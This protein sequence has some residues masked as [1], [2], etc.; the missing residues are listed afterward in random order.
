MDGRGDRRRQAG[1]ETDVVARVLPRAQDF[2]FDSEL[3]AFGLQ[4]AHGLGLGLHERPIIS[5]LNSLAAPDRTA[6]GHGV[7]HG[8]LLPGLRRRLSRAH[9]GGGRRHRHRHRDPHQ[10]PPRSY[11]WRTSTDPPSGQFCSAAEAERSGSAPQ[12]RPRRCRG[13]QASPY[14]DCNPP[15][16]GQREDDRERSCH[17]Q[18]TR[19]FTLS[20][21]AANDDASD[22]SRN[23]RAAGGRGGLH[24]RVMDSGRHRTGR[25]RWPL[26][27][28]G[29]GGAAIAAAVV[30]VAIGLT[31]VAGGQACA[32]AAS[33]AG[34][35]SRHRH[36]L[37]AL[38]RRG[39]PR[40]PF[41]PGGGLYVA[42]VAAGVRQRRP[43]RQLPGRRRPGRFG[44]RRG[45]RP[46][47]AVRGRST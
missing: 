33:S 21:S 11:S 2:G 13:Q 38:S 10:F 7:R 1:R 5:R 3:A 6:G 47:P 43:V 30:A 28:F 18:L 34:G 27:G 40:L 19:S 22:G 37:R 44:P 24:S 26:L 15:G 31:Q 29:L 42:L 39:Q 16:E 25:T 35:V 23:A 8:D 32:S 9:R 45:R 41:P 36:A 4:F 14:V 12:A 20:G 17:P 46:V